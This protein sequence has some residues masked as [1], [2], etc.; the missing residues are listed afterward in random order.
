MGSLKMGLLKVIFLDS[1]GPIQRK[2]LGVSGIITSLRDPV[3]IVSYG[4]KKSF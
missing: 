2:G 4:T 1:L 3:S